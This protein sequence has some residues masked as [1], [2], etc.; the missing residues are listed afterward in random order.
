M[1][2]TYDL[3]FIT[4]LP[5]FY[6]V[7]LYNKIAQ[8]KRVFVIFISNASTIR[9]A[10]F[11]QSDIQFDYCVLNQCPFEKRNQII[12]MVALFKKMSSISYQKLIVGGWDLL[13]FWLAVLYSK[14]DKN[15]LA[16]ESS[17]YESAT[18]GLRAWIK[19]GFLS[20]ISLVYPSGEPHQ[21]LL[22]ALN[23]H[24]KVKTTHGVGIFNYQKRN[25][26][27]KRFSAQFLY[28]GR[29]APEK[30]LELLISVFEQLPHFSLTLVGQGPLEKSL[31]KRLPVNVKM[32]GHISNHELAHL[33][34]AHDVLVLPSLREPWGLVVEEALYHGLPVIVSD[35]VGC[36]N[37]LVLRQQVGTTFD[38]NNP[39]ALAHALL[40]MSQHYDEC[41]ANVLKLDFV[42]KEA[43]QI[44]Q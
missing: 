25:L 30:N 12:S 23:Y 38:S 15:Q 39:L 20:R 14:L 3:L 41:I 34:A 2:P 9:T 31:Q 8:T 28:V 7:N 4:H 11:T 43:H 35:K 42:Q 22:T 16:L 21:A 33:Y 13:E 40:W 44:Q 5:A 19:K 27:Q 18:S 24:G 17:I 10:D 36:A 37:D 32:L 29:L 1:K 26:N 6:K